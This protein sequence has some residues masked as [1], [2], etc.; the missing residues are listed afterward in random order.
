MIDYVQ[1][2]NSNEGRSYPF[3]DDASLI[4]KAGNKL[5][6]NLI[7][8]LSI[9]VPADYIAGVHCPQIKVT[10]DVISL[11]IAS[12]T[13]GLFMGTYS[14]SDIIPYT[15]YPLE[16]L[17]ADIYGWVVFGSY[18]TKQKEIYRFD[19]YIDSELAAKAMKVVDPLPLT[20]LVKLGDDPACYV[21]KVIKLVSGSNINIYKDSNFIY[22]GLIHPEE[23]I[24]PC[25]PAIDIASERRTLHSI[26]GVKPD[27][28]GMITLRF[29]R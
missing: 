27:A 17:V 19:S 14:T 12:D 8:D 29:D 2:Y 15:A 7:I 24:G 4:D 25:N 5:P 23:V 26:N 11:G 6:N 1:W 9:T 22:I 10:P 21:S 18:K 13:A 16:S 20:K 28:D 3:K